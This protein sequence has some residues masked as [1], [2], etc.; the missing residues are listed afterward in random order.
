MRAV[1]IQTAKEWGKKPSEVGLCSEEDDIAYMV[2]WEQAE[3]KMTAWEHQEQKK[4]ADRKAR[5]HSGGR[6]RRR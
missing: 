3:S 2:A 5:T 4:E 1:L 6:G